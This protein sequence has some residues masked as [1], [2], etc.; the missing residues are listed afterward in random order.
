MPERMIPK[1]ELDRRVAVLRR[2]RELLQRQRDKFHEYLDV[3]EREKADIEA[4]DVDAMV[5]HVEIEQQI[6]SEL[7]TFQKVIDPLEDMYREAYPAGTEHDVSGFKRGIDALRAD[8][9][10]RNARNRD[11][12]KQKMGMLRQEIQSLRNPTKRGKQVY[13]SSGEASIIDITS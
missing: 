9:L 12:L 1:E 8:V 13:S 5:S 11:L 4:G 7:Y 6:V 10:A 3:L 2:F